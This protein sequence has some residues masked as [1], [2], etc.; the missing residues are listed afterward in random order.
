MGLGL[1]VGGFAFVAALVFAIWRLARH[2]LAFWV[3]LL[4]CVA[5]LALGVGA[6][7]LETMAGPVS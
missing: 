5:Q 1:G 3:P 6:A 2:R 7:G 4:G